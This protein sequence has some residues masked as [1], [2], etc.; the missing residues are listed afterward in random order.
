M[1]N[2]KSPKERQNDWIE[3]TMNSYR[4]RQTMSPPDELFKRIEQVIDKDTRSSKKLNWYVPFA[5]AIVLLLVNT[6]AVVQYLE[7]TNSSTEL[8]T[9]NYL[10]NDYNLYDYE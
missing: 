2:D 8:T 3:S 1:N 5:A 10:I 4:G 6:T 7:I 9:E